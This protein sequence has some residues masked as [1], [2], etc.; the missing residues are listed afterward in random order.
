MSP[1]QEWRWICRICLSASPLSDNIC[2]IVLGMDPGMLSTEFRE[3]SYVTAFDEAEEAILYRHILPESCWRL[4]KWLQIGKEKKL[5]RGVKVVEHFIFKRISLKQE[6]LRKGEKEGMSYDF[7]TAYMENDHAGHQLSAAGL[8]ISHK[9][10]RDTAINLLA[11][12]KDTISAALSWFFWLIATHPLVENKIWE[13]IIK[14]NNIREIKDDKVWWIF[15]AEEVPKLVYL[16]G[17]L[18]ETLRLFPPVPLEHKAPISQWPQNWT[19]F[20]S[21]ILSV[22]NGE[23]GKHMGARLLRIQA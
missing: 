18:C 10:L 20:R 6:R 9:F 23:D 5:S 22:C 16:H 7:L 21:D 1:L 15:S 3:E 11:A 12:G 8:E 17:A 4:Q 2:M 19:R 13:E 14:A